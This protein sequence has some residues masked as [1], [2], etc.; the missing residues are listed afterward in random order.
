MNRVCLLLILLL[1]VVAVPFATADTI[2]I[3]QTNL[4]PMNI[5]SVTLTQ[6]GGNVMVTLNANPG[7]SFTIGGGAFVAFNTNASMTSGSF[8]SVSIL[9]TNGKNY[10][11]L[12]F[13]S[14]NTDKNFS[15]FGTFSVVLHGLDNSP[16]GAVTATTMSFVLKGVT[17]QQFEGNWGVHFC[18]NNP[19]GL[20]CTNTGFAAGN[21]P[22]VVP[23]PGTLTLLGTGIIGLAGLMRRRF[24][25]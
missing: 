12:T 1:A 15:K 16:H 22:T 17:V 18:I 21:K 24:L 5:G 3:T 8:G 2:Q 25:K 19:S 23:E 4:G 6:Q 20:G 9:G 14:F 13:S 10:T 11:G 7:F